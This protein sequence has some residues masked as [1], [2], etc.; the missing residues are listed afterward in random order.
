MA[1]TFQE[2]VGNEV[3]RQQNIHRRIN[4]NGQKRQRSEADFL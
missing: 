4:S 2:K 1:G 3:S